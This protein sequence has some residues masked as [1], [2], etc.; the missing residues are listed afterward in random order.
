ML[1]FPEGRL[2]PGS[3]RVLFGSVT[4]LIV[5]LYAG[6]ALFVDAYPT[7]TPWAFCDADCPPN[8]FMVVDR[9]PAIVDNLVIPARELLGVVLL[10][11][12]TWWLVRRL[13]AASPLQRRANA[14]VVAM[15]VAWLAT[16]VAYLVTRRAA[17]DAAAVGTVG[18]IWS[19]CIPA[20]AAAFFAGIV[21]RRIGLGE[22][23][24]ASG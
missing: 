6:S 17:P 22:L 18:R 7:H 8:A 14:P 11:A 3:P 20:I 10:A 9:Q 19:L 1:A 15:S 2:A 13:R 12:V 24:S 5:V 4:G 23:L 16:L 21:R